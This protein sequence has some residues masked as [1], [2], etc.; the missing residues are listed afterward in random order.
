MKNWISTAFLTAT[1]ALTAPAF[2]QE[3]A[4]LRGEVTAITDDVVTVTTQGGETYE[5]A[6]ND[7]YSMIVYTFMDIADVKMGDFLSIPSVTGDNG[8]KVAMSINVFPEAMRGTN[9]GEVAWDLTE[10]SLM[11]NATV[12]EVV[13]AVDGSVI[14]VMYEGTEEPVLVPADTPIT[15]FGPDPDRKL[16]QGDQVLMFV[17]QGDDGITSGLVGVTEDG[18]LP[19][20]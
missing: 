4:R 3:T 17:Q 16:E 15:R 19:P 11:T 5:V 12:G 2:A 20:V 6:M 14:L 8:E 1:M 13:T 18:S 10:D 9:E 7:N